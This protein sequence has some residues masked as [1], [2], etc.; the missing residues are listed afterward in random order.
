MPRRLDLDLS[1]AGY[2]LFLGE[3]N[4]KDH[5]SPAEA[6]RLH[7]AELG[8]NEYGIFYIHI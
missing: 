3:L 4:N 7:W 6:G 5:L 8:K 2:K 1:C